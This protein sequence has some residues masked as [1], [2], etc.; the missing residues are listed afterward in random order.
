[1]GKPGKHKHN[2]PRVSR[3]GC[4]MCKPHKHGFTNPNRM[5][6]RIQAETLDAAFEEYG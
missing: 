4:A 5:Q 3:A 2:R 6:L 1:M